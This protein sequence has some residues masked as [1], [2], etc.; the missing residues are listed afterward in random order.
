MLNRIGRTLL[1]SLVDI[2]IKL[3]CL[4]ILEGVGGERGG[5]AGWLYIYIECDTWEKI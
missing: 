1:Y 5:E 3:D 2:S 4:L